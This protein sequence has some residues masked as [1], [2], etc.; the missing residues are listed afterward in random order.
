ME[1]RSKIC[2]ADGFHRAN[3]AKS[4]KKLERTIHLESS[5]DFNRFG[6]LNDDDPE[7]TC[8][9]NIFQK[10]SKSLVFASYYKTR[11]DKNIFVQM[12]KQ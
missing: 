10:W 9:D 4:M 3:C 6:I 5:T 2:I 1:E 11:G 12:K 7:V 8:L